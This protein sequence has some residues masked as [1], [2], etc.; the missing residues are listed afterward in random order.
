MDKLSRYSSGLAIIITEAVA[1]RNYLILIRIIIV[2][3]QWKRQ[4]SSS[5]KSFYPVPIAN[6]DYTYRF[7]AMHQLLVNPWAALDKLR[8]IK[9]RFCAINDPKSEVCNVSDG[10]DGLYS[11]SP[12][13][14]HLRKP[15]PP[16]LLICVSN[17]IPRPPAAAPYIIHIA[18]TGNWVKPP[19]L[20]TQPS[21][22][23]RLLSNADAVCGG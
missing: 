14:V 4:I 19:L 8:H 16:P 21:A 12:E 1:K 22:T 6:D 13:H 9:L 15:P 3:T 7:E 11:G 5:W 10:L 2:T 17:A 23:E 18:S 20:V